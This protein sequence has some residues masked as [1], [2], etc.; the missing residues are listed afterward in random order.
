M[1]SGNNFLN[2]PITALIDLYIEPVVIFSG[3]VVLV[4]AIEALQLSL[5]ETGLFMLVLLRMLPI[6]KTLHQ[7]YQ[8]FAAAAGSRRIL[9]DTYFWAN[10][11]AEQN[12]GTEKLKEPVSIHFKD[13]NFRYNENQLVLNK[14]NLSFQKGKISALIGPAGAGK[15]TI[16]ELMLRIYESESGYIYFGNDKIESLDL[17]SLRLNISLVTQDSYFIEGTI[18]ENLTISNSELQDEQILNTIQKVFGQKFSDD[19]PEE[20]DT[21]IGFCGFRL[22][23]GQRPSID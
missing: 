4:V 10:S 12:T 8:S 23:G 15:S 6:S 19:F 21:Q 9:F 13:V 18:R 7:S 3:S 22:S 11:I 5:S 14:V 16:I 20:L 1:R 2:L 17:I